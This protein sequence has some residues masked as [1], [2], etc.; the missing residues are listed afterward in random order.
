MTLHFSSFAGAIWLM[1]M[2]STV[3][4]GFLE[5]L[6]ELLNT[7]LLLECRE[8]LFFFFFL[9]FDF[10]SLAADIQLFIHH[11]NCKLITFFIHHFVLQVKVITDL[12]CSGRFSVIWS[13]K[14]LSVM[15]DVKPILFIWQQMSLS[16]RI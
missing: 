12:Y 4:T 7:W 9:M 3:S 8:S 11:F 2:L 15:C 14:S 6:G 5:L 13:I 10:K 1:L 16:T